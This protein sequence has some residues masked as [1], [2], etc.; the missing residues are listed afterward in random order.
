MITALSGQR[1]SEAAGRCNGD[2]IR[3]VG[4]IRLVGRDMKTR[5]SIAG[6]GGNWI[7]AGEAGGNQSR[8][9]FAVASLRRPSQDAGGVPY[10]GIPS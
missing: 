1:G 4:G 9:C 10:A 3:L 6:G 8:P 5:P 2:L 7:E